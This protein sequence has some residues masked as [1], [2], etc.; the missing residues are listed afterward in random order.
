MAI[1]I[2]ANFELI[3]QYGKKWLYEQANMD[4]PMLSSKALTEVNISQSVGVVQVKAGGFGTTGLIADGSAYATPD[5][6]EPYRG[7][8]QPAILNSNGK[9]PLGM[10]R[11]AQGG[12]GIAILK[13]ELNSMGRDHY[14][15]LE[16]LII[17]NTLSPPVGTVS[18]GATSFP[19]VDASGYVVGATIDFYASG[20]YQESHRVT[21]VAIPGSGNATITIGTAAVAA[22]TG[23]TAH[24]R[25]SQVS[26]QQMINFDGVINPA[27][28]LYGLATAVFPGGESTTLATLTFAG[29]RALLARIAKRAGRR[30]QVFIVNELNQNR[31]YD[32]QTQNVRFV[33]GQSAKIDP[34]DMKLLFNGM[35][36]VTTEQASDRVINFINTEDVK[37]HVFDKF[38]GE[39]DGFK[40]SAPNESGVRKSEIGHYLLLQFSG[41]Y[42][43][44][45]SRRNGCAQ[46]TGITA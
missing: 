7:T 45:V 23:T 22:L 4:S 20:V 29:I 21:D 44:R 28:T 8:Y 14:R 38:G 27:A 19:V 26:G 35:K 6:V 31:I 43:L 5:D 3:Q 12:D 10:A 13:E 30:P 16:R 1:S 32:L 42:N 33:E 15:T 36:S 37:L 18:I 39:L 11:V 9:V 24:I 46:L 34:Y 41:M 2:G 25:G 40:K 17:A